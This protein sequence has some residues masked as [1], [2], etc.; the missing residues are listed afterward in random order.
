MIEISIEELEKPVN[1]YSPFDNL[2]T[3]I[4]DLGEG[5]FG[6]VIKAIDNSTREELAIKILPKRHNNYQM[7]M[8]E[9][10]ILKNLSHPNIVK[11][12]NFVETDNYI[13]IVMEYLR[14]GTLKQYI[15][16][17]KE[18]I[19][20]DT[21]RIIIKQLLSA[22]YYLH[23]ECDVCHRDIKPDNIMLSEPN[24]ITSIKLLD[25]GL[26]SD[27]FENKSFVDNC[28]TLIYM[29][30]EQ[31]DNYSYSKSVDIWS[32]GIITFMM[33]FQGKHPFYSLGD[34]NKTIIHKLKKGNI[35]Y[36][37]NCKHKPTPISRDFIEKILN[38]IPSYRYSSKLALNHPW[39]TKKKFDE[40]PVNLYEKLRI[41]ECKKKMHLLF[42]TVLFLQNFNLNENKFDNL[43]EYE[44]SVKR[45]NELSKQLFQQ[46]R[47]KMFLPGE[48]IK[49]IK[50]MKLII[51]DHTEKESIENKIIIPLIQ[52]N[53]NP[54]SKINYNK[55]KY[56][57]NNDKGFRRNSRLNTV[58]NN[59]INMEY[60]NQINLNRKY[61]IK[62]LS[63][64]V[65]NKSK[66]LELSSKRNQNEKSKKVTPNKSKN[67]KKISSNKTPNKWYNPNSNKLL[68]KIRDK[69][70]PNASFLNGSRNVVKTKNKII[71][72]NNKCKNT[73]IPILLP[74]IIKQNSIF[75]PKNKI[76]INKIR[77]KI[78][79]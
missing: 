39:I 49:E 69:Q 4:C 28:G 41:K 52:E 79:V 42:C 70:S 32:I 20:E 35:H 47:N 7:L 43:D 13:Y 50:D 6:K 54:N 51:E 46:K 11:F 12:E 78:I 62:D 26:S 22:A 72:I 14:G 19:S 65:G 67:G 15:N 36:H 8:K 24:D 2:Y 64:L 37:K 75:N 3:K 71:Q 29:A 5:A 57:Q 66:N 61:S 76:D 56:N 38:K 40:I 74:K 16:N 25:F 18:L 48:S 55:I 45:A 60:L 77:T 59:K 33:L 73:K 31:I 30:P 10:N 53:K 9:V 44:K 58:A 68:A 27:S 63:V 1:T 23:N 17:N 34:D 21:V